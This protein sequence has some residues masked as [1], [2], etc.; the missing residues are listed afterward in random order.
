MA[1]EE[2]PSEST[3]PPQEAPGSETQATEL[4][5]QYASLLN[6][7]QNMRNRRRQIHF[8]QGSL[9][10]QSQAL[11]LRNSFV[12]LFDELFASLF[13]GLLVRVLVFF[14]CCLFVY[15]LVCLLISLFVSC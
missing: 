12:C 4:L 6:P 14:V 13:V 8:D 7:Q 15:L 5:K 1:P 9:P 11:L 10:N 3:S 2:T